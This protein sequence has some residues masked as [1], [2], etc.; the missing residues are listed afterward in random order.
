MQA[1]VVF[2]YSVGFFLYRVRIKEPIW[3]DHPDNILILC[4]TCTYSSEWSAVTGSIELFKLNVHLLACRTYRTQVI[5]QLRHRERN[6][7]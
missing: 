7:S 5:F 3:C 1:A 4:N 6:E 2:T